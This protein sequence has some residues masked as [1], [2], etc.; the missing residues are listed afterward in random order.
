MAALDAAGQHRRPASP[1]A[2]APATRAAA[3][4]AILLLLVLTTLNICFALVPRPCGQAVVWTALQPARQAAL[5]SHRYAAWSML[6][7]AP[8]TSEQCSLDYGPAWLATQAA[9]T[10]EVCSP[11]SHRRGRMGGRGGGSSVR[12][13]WQPG[14]QQPL[15][16]C[17]A[18]GLVLANSS[19]FVG[20]GSP[21]C[22]TA[23]AAGA[24]ASNCTPSAA[25]GSVQL[26][27]KPAWGMA[28]A[29]VPVAAA[30]NAPAATPAAAALPASLPYSIASAAE[31][32]RLP[33]AVTGSLLL[34]RWMGGLAPAAGAGS[35]VA[36]A[37][38]VVQHPVLFVTRGDV[39]NYFHTMEHCVSVWAAL[40]ALDLPEVEQQGLQVRTRTCQCAQRR[41]SQAGRAGAAQL[42]PSYS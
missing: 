35:F 1:T 10:V 40:A 42:P 6:H 31:G 28:A 39:D 4:A 9:N 16:T 2:W 18:R 13:H 32:Q 3:G 8:D 12:C 27:C 14:T 24:H 26:S 37:G 15:V 11:D 19:A 30:E 29:G 34:Q 20:P 25:S 23:G 22:G 33:K 38:P 41:A 21:D 5:A 17:V 7:A 36:A